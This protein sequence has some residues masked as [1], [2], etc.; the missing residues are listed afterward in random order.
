M[1]KTSEPTRPDDAKNSSIETTMI[2]SNM[3]VT[4]T[5][6]IPISKNNHRVSIPLDDPSID[7]DTDDAVPVMM[8][9]DDT[10]TKDNISS[11]SSSSISSS[12]RHHGSTTQKIFHMDANEC[13][14]ARMG[15]PQL[16]NNNNNATDVQTSS[17]IQKVYS[18]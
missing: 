3:G 16:P 18:I 9:D 5:F 15:L 4:L 2:G 8:N 13:I 10:S 17:N 14:S 11:S 12:L 1:V 6:T 7:I